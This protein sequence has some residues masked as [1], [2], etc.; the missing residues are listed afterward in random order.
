MRDPYTYLLGFV[1]GVEE[2]NSDRLKSILFRPW[3]HASSWGTGTP[4]H[5]TV[6][7]IHG[8]TLRLAEQDKDISM[9]A[10]LGWWARSLVLEDFVG[11]VKVQSS[12]KRLWS[13][14]NFDAGHNVVGVLAVLLISATGRVRVCEDQGV[15]V[16][17]RECGDFRAVGAESRV[18]FWALLGLRDFQFIAE[19]GFN[20]RAVGDGDKTRGVEGVKD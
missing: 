13:W 17:S 14:C 15:R 4:S 1:L 7:L 10:S 3:P 9:E 2:V 12:C 11:L 8:G 19:G 18:D 16:F 5:P 20:I 6:S